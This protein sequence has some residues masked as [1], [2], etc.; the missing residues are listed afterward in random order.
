LAH[1]TGPW[2]AEGLRLVS[3]R[4]A[5][6]R[7]CWPKVPAPLHGFGFQ[8]A[9]ALGRS[10][11]GKDCHPRCFQLG[12][13][14]IGRLPWSSAAESLAQTSGQAAQ[15]LGWVGS[16]ADSSWRRAPS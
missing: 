14:T 12:I 8:V 5:R 3:A 10:V 1:G 16:L 2:Q 11:W 7:W 13:A 9:Q 6:F 15:H 4:M